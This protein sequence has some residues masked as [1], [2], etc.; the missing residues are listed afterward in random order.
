MR[1]SG[2]SSIAAIVVL[3]GS[4]S[5]FAQSVETPRALNATTV[6][7]PAEPSEPSTVERVPT[8]DAPAPAEAPA[9]VAATTTMQSESISVPGTS[10]RAGRVHVEVHAPYAT[11]AAVITDFARYRDFFPQL[12]ESRVIHR[13]R[14]QADVYLRVELMRGLGTLWALSRFNVQRTADA[15]T[16]EGTMVDGN[17]RRL[18]VRFEAR[19]IAGDPSRSEVT[20]Q[21]LGVPP[22]FV[23]EGLLNSQ[24]SHWAAR[25]V[26]LLRARAEALTSQAAAAR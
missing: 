10:V 8:P 19:A 3:L 2:C 17:L 20:M 1:A 4:A 21:L 11:V 18:E 9:P 6:A 13:R 22:F 25:G 12:G 24:Q 16:V 14:G 7:R 26:E 5:G 23:P 15:T